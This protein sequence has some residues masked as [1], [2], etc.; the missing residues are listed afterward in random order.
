[1][2]QI[3]FV[4]V[5]DADV[6]LLSRIRQHDDMRVEAVYHPDPG[7]LVA[8]IAALSR[9]PVVSDRNRLEGMTPDVCI[10]GERAAEFALEWRERALLA[11]RP[12]PVF[13]SVDRAGEYLDDVEGF[14]ARIQREG[15]SAANGEL[16]PVEFE[17]TSHSTRNFPR[18]DARDEAPAAAGIVDAAPGARP[19]RHRRPKRPHRR[20]KRPHRRPS[21]HHLSRRPRPP[22]RRRRRCPRRRPRRPQLRPPPPRRWKRSRKTPRSARLPSTSAMTRVGSWPG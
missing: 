1:M 15:A 7:S 12:A 4:A 17:V 11:G 8:R 3:V 18:D 2:K 21:R 16:E 20:P 13:V 14:L 6:D 22:P 10:G 5:D 19:R 9:L